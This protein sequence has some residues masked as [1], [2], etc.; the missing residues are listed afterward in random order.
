MAKWKRYCAAF[1]L[2]FLF[3]LAMPVTAEANSRGVFYRPAL[4]FVSENAPS[5]LILRM[6]IQRGEE[7]I[8]VFLFR[9]DRLWES[10]FRLYRQT[11]QSGFIWYGNRVDFENAVLVAET[12]GRETRI[13]LPEDALMKLTMNDFFM[14]DASDFSLTFGLPLWRTILLFFL[15]LVITLAASLLILY[16]FQYRWKKSWIVV[17]IITVICQGALSLFLSNWINYN[18]KMLAVV[19]LIMMGILL[20]QIPIYWWLL[21]ED[22]TKKSVSF[23]VCA[24][25]ATSLLNLMFLIQFPL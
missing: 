4:T 7:N 6:D 8:Q 1:L 25:V 9:E 2:V 15:R 22:E 16:F 17:I 24:N 19:F 23:A 12:G 21:D 20:V 13:P 10:Y 3:M 11:A 14:L 5:D 18:P